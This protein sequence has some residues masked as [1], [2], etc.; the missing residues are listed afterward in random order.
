M[1]RRTSSTQPVLLAY[2]QGVAK[3]HDL[4][5]HIRFETE[6][7]EAG[8]DEARSVWKVKIR[9]KD[10]RT[11]TLEAKAVITAVGQLNQP[12]YPD[13]PG[14]GEFKGPAFHSARWRPEVDLKGKRVAVIGTGA[15]AFQFAPEVAKEA[16]SLNVF[17][18]TPPVA[19]AHR[20]LPRPGHA[21]R[22]LAAGARALL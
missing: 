1:A 12:R 16:A 22:A 10:G 11:E 2:F 5:P 18:R 19:R 14:V 7:Q 3:K 6:V 13:I 15:S 4:R 17:Q 8:F 9:G 21:G 20:R